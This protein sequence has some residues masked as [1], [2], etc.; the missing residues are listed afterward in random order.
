[1]SNPLSRVFR[2]R[3]ARKQDAAAKASIAPD[4]LTV[5]EFPS[6]ITSLLRLYGVSGS[7]GAIYATQPNVRIVVDTIAREGA[8]LNLKMYQRDERGDS[9]PS[10]RILIMDHPMMELLDEPTPGESTYRFWYSLFADISI[11]DI[12]FWLKIRQGRRIR[13]LVRVPPANITPE[14]DPI[15]QRVVRWRAADGSTI[16]TDDLVVFWGYDPQAGHGN[17]PPMA[18][19]RRLLADEAAAAANREGM[20]ANALRKDG[21]IEQHI[22]APKMSDEAIESY[23]IDLEDALSGAAGSGRPAI[24]QP[25]HSWKDVTWSPQEM[26]WLEARKLSR[27]EAAAAFHMPAKMVNADGDPDEATLKV[28]YKKTLR[29]LL[30]RVESEIEAQL[31]PEFDLVKSVR[32]SRYVEFNLDAKLRGSF[33]EIAQIGATAVGGPVVTLNEWRARLNLPPLPDGDAIMVPLNTVRGGGPQASPRSPTET[34]AAGLEPVGTTPGGGSAGLRSAQEESVEEVLQAHE[35][36]VQARKSRDEQAEF[37]K[38]QR[39]RLEQQHSEALE[40]HFE[41]QDAATKGRGMKRSRWDRELADDLFAVLYP[42]VAAVGTG[43]GKQVG[44][45]FDQERTGPYLREKANATA[46]AINDKT[47]EHLNAG[48]DREIVYGKER[49]D[50]LAAS[51]ATFTVGWA[52][53]EVAN[54][55]G[56]QMKKTWLTT[57]RNPRSSHAA[58]DGETV[59]IWEEFGN[60]LMYPGDGDLGP[61]EAANCRCIMI[62]EN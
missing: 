20:W 50:K 57:S 51:L 44:V 24:L 25:G 54:Q 62:V 14:R 26:E 43:V 18:T 59:M 22:D 53:R 39:E 13:A 32:R 29:P 47:E 35:R 40:R 7:Y 37:L 55:S 34:P 21:I 52:V 38:S 2:G 1:M 5:T 12:A 15:T 6:R 19:L 45:D 4:G 31:L 28:F 10:G 41:R 61:E 3:A 46:K 9:L 48:V 33:E 8:E 36:R 17:V 60:G 56:R 16:A 58:V 23:L 11:Y 27:V 49:R 42:G 30:N